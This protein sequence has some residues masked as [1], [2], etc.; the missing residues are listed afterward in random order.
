MAHADSVIGN[1]TDLLFSNPQQAIR[2]FDTLQSQLTDSAAWYK[3]E[4]FKATAQFDGRHLF[5]KPSLCKSGTLESEHATSSAASRGIG[6]EPSGC[7]C[8][9]GGQHPSGTIVLPTSL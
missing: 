6:V 1:H 7:K 2:V 9:D 3:A 8:H 5:G 4:V